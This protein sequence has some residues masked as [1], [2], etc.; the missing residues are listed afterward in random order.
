MSDLVPCPRCKAV[1][2]HPGGPYIG[3]ILCRPLRGKVTPAL[4]I[5]YA[6]LNDRDTP[7]L[8]EY[9]YEIRERHIP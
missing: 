1:V 8:M 7:M 6:L 5:E 4:A 2:E 3:C 9:A